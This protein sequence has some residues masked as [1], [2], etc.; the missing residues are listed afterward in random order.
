MSHPTWTPARTLDPVA[1]QPVP[2]TNGAAVAALVTGLMGF[3]II[4][5]VLGHLAL[6]QLRRRGERGS[7]LAVVGL[8]LG[9]G[10]CALY[11]LLAVLVVAGV[12]GGVLGGAR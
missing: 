7:T 9:Y 10:Q 4:P 3:A 8:V 11:V 6:A 2:S 12:V 1:A 5:V